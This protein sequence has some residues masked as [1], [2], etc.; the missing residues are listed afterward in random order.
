M[1]TDYD[2]VVVGGGLAG[3]SLGAALARTGIRVLIAER[4][5]QFRDRVR[6]EALQPWGAA[7]ARELKFYRPLIEACAQETRWW[8]TPEENRD[9]IET[10]PFPTWV[11]EL[12]SS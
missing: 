7:E 10:T 3:A 11:S 2:V 1:L 6:V 5:A 12:L 4:E 8:T 9:L